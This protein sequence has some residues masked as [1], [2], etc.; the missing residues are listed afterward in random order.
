MR[1]ALFTETFLPKV[2]GI[3]NTLCHLLEHLAVRGHDSILFAP[4]SPAPVYARTPL[5]TFSGRPFPL[6]PEL[7]LVSPT[8]NIRQHLLDFQPDLVHAVQPITLG[9]AGI[10]HARRL[11]IPVVA[12]Y[13]TDIAGYAAQWGMEWLQGPIWHTFRAIHDKADLNLC[14]STATLRQLQAQNFPRLRV[15]TRGVDTTQFHP[16]WRSSAWRQRLSDGH[17]DAPLL[18]YVGRLSLEKRVDWLR[19]LLDQFPH[20]RLSIVGDGPARDKLEQLFAGTPTH[21]TGYLRGADLAHAYAAADAFTFPSAHETLGN[22]VLE[23]MASGL[24]VV[25]ARS[26]GPLDV[27]T[28]GQNGLFFDP[29]D[30]ADFAAQVGKLLADAP[31]AAQLGQQARQTAERRSW[32]QVLDG[33]LADYAEVVAGRET[34]VA[35]SRPAIATRRPAVKSPWPNVE[36]WRL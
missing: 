8:V 9:T 17:P 21:F 12:S 26:G 1:I 6:Y 15:W 36:G 5:V 35:P 29:D 14:P 19:P 34:A 2:D 11:G 20:I 31:L 13:H 18:L 30:P 4:T 32:T 3:V 10:W 28:Q 22:V 23:A 33:L 27:V 7:K 24:P 16:Q 25:V